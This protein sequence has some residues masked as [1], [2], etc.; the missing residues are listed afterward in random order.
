MISG[1]VSYAIRR[2][3]RKKTCIK[4][5]TEYAIKLEHISDKHTANNRQTEVWWSAAL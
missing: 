1:R 4:K 5:E 2:I 3:K